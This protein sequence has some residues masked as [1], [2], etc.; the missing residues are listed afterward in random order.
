LKRGLEEH[1][2]RRWEWTW[3]ML[4]DVLIRIHN[5][6]SDFREQH[7]TAS[8]AV[9]IAAVCAAL[10]VIGP[11]LLVGVL[12]ML[13]FTAVGP[14][15]GS[16]AAAVQAAVY[17]GAVQVGSPFALAQAAAM[18]GIVVAPIGAQIAAGAVAVAGLWFGFG[19]KLELLPYGAWVNSVPFRKRCQY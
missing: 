10:V 15:A 9:A 8:K 17:G 18:G 4:K 2:G 3:P 1:T 13:G 5:A 11:P 16:F 12:N 19:K 6:I 14:A 7:P